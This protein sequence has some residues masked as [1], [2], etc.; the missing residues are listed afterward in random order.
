MSKGASLSIRSS[1]WV[2]VVALVLLGFLLSACAPASPTAAPEP[3]AVP[4]SVEP[5]S[6]TQETPASPEP[7]SPARDETR[8]QP[9]Y[10]ILLAGHAGSVLSA[11]FSPD[12][13][14]VL[15]AGDD[16]TAI[17]WDAL[18]GEQI[19]RFQGH[20]QSLT[21]AHFD[22]TG[23]RVVTAGYDGTVR[24]WHAASGEPRIVLRGH[25]GIVN[26]AR[27][28][29]AGDRVLSAG[30]D[31]TARIWEAQTGT[32]LA[33]LGGD[34]GPVHRASFSP[35]GSQVATANG[36]G[37]VRI[38]E[39]A[40]GSQLYVLPESA[41]AGQRSNLAV[42]ALAYSPDGATLLAAG[43][44][45]TVNL[46]DTNSGAN[47]LHIIAHGRGV[48]W[49]DLSPDGNR[50]L[51]A[52]FLAGVAS[53]W[54]AIN[55]AAL[56]TLNHGSIIQDLAFGPD[57]RSVATA[58]SDGVVR[59]WDAVSGELLAVLEG[60]SDLVW[61]VAFSPDGEELVTASQDGTARIWQLS[62]GAQALQEPAA[63]QPAGLSPEGPWWV[64]AGAEGLWAVNQDG[65]GATRISERDF[66]YYNLDIAGWASPGGGHLAYITTEEG[67]FNASLHIVTLPDTEQETVIGL[68]VEGTE[69]SRDS[70]PG[71]PALD[72][73][74]VVIQDD[75][76]A[77]SPDGRWLAFTGMLQ[78]ST[79]DLY[80]Y[81]TTTGQVARLT[82]GPSQ[83]ARPVWSPDGQSIL[84]AAL[85]GANIDT[86][87][88][89][90]SHWVAARDGSAVNLVNEGE[91]QFVGWTGAGE[92][93][94]YSIDTLCGQ[95]DLR[96]V[97][98][99]NGSQ[100]IWKGYFNRVAYEPESGAV[101]LALWA[102]TASS[103]L[104]GVDQGP[105][106][107]LTNAA[108]AAPMRLVEDEVREMIWSPEARLFF[109]RTDFGI[110]AVAL[111]GDF[112]DLA[113]PE[114]SFGFPQ[115]AP[116]IREL[117]WRGDGLWLGLL[118]SS[119]DQPPR[120]IHPDRTLQAGWAPDDSRLLFIG[121]DGAL[122]NA[123]RPDLTPEFI[124]EIGVPSAAVWLAP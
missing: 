1:R 23:E 72:A 91:A 20:D 14:R 53:T 118:T 17:S 62:A 35:N 52:S 80:L 112:I 98:L 108:G 113:V 47:Q 61:T 6:P 41:L 5:R 19:A 83:A 2:I 59:V 46:W 57:N 15:T 9:G 11:E 65:T 39:A 4:A 71:D 69:P 25:Q 87:M 42:R 90:R 106:L 8:P 50:I 24:L 48:T 58:G 75:S 92:L 109:G 122:F 18:T 103:D 86:G 96:T 28:D 33:V 27:F 95:H 78:G 54:S 85:E 73:V 115:V 3:T 68:T 13:S 99:A 121:S 51:S 7:S 77:W 117:A 12:G 66:S 49:A 56:A 40:G 81:D 104:C 97:G 38:W 89:V 29:P 31:G 37:T 36:D 102:D 70:A 107:Y 43:E 32:S 34:N 16:Q 55:G 105:G 22:G 93:I 74:S 119:I 26:D 101:L 116:G 76:F 114:S 67:Y 111:S 10:P 79:S 30:D 44:D 123:Q 60:H 124:T 45:G 21:T 64:L 82:D 88:H 120:Q 110:L 100:S 84:H 94:F 63:G